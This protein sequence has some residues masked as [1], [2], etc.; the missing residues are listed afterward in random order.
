MLALLSARLITSLGQIVVLAR[1]TV[2]P[3]QSPA[4]QPAW[5]PAHP[6]PSLYHR[7][8]PYTCWARPTKDWASRFTAPRTTCV[9]SRSPSSICASLAGTIRGYRGHRP[10]RSWCTPL[11]APSYCATHQTSII[12]TPWVCRLSAALLASVSTTP[13]DGSGWPALVR[14]PSSCP[15]FHASCSWSST[16]PTTPGSYQ[17]PVRPMRIRTGQMWAAL[18]PLRQLYCESLCTRRGKFLLSSTSAGCASI[19]TSKIQASCLCCRLL[20]SLLNTWR[21]IRSSYDLYDCDWW[22]FSCHLSLFLFRFFF[23]YAMY[24]WVFVSQIGQTK[25]SQG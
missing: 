1:Q 18:Q 14:R 21:S 3:A 15:S 5:H 13:R 19:A 20:H 17:C 24:L 7:L 10:L 16:T 2:T 8:L 12:C 25:P 6:C 11:L 4:G 9:S 22:W 23:V